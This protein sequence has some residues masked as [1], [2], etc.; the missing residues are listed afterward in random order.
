MIDQ[1][2][3]DA[4]VP[5]I[6]SMIVWDKVTRELDWDALSLVVTVAPGVVQM[7]GFAYDAAGKPTPFVPDADALDDR[8]K[9]LAEAM[10]EPEGRV[11]KSAL[12]QIVRATSKIHFDFEYDDAGR[13]KVT[14]ANI[15]TMPEQ[16]RPK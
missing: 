11:W 10:R 1:Q 6:G 7:H 14:P 2:R 3:A 15:A 8:F 4:L 9:E 12:V 13:W 5:E 16:L